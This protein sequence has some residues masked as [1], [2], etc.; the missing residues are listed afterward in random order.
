MFK[1][2]VTDPGKK[3]KKGRLTLERD[4]SGALVTVTDSKGDAEKDL[5]VEVFK[6]GELKKEY[7]FAEVRE[8]A[9]ISDEVVAFTPAAAAAGA[10]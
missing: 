2:P 4:A 3:S 6:D 5:L 10:E 1:D 9:S 8:R 7:T